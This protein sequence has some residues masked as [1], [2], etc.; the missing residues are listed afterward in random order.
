MSE[1]SVN[2]KKINS[3]ADTI[4]RQAR[5]L[6]EASRSVENVKNKIKMQSESGARIASALKISRD[7]L[8]SQAQSIKNM[9]TA[10]RNIAAAYRQAEEQI[11]GGN[12][13]LGHASL[14]G[15]GSSG[16]GGT[17]TQNGGPSGCS[18]FSPDPVNLNTGNFILDNH[19]LEINGFQPLVFHRFYNSMST[20]SGMLGNDWHAF[21][22]IKLLLAPKNGM[23]GANVCLILEDGREEYFSMKNGKDF[24]P[25]SA[26]TSELFKKED[27][28]YLYRA[29]N[30]DQYHFD[31]TG[32][33]TRYENIRGLGFDLVYEN[34]RLDRIIKDSGEYFALHEND[35][36][37][38]EKIEDHTGRSCRYEYADNHLQK[39]VLPDGSEYHYDYNIFGKISCVINPRDVEAVETQYDTLHRITYQ[40]FA[41]GTTNE[42]TYQDEEKAVIMIERNGTKSIHYH[43]DEYQNVRNVYPDGEESFEYNNRGQKTKIIAKNGNKISLQYDNKGNLAGILTSDGTKIAATYNHLNQLVTMSVN[44]KRKLKNQYNQYGDLLDTEDGLGRRTSYLYNEKGQVTEARMPDGTV[45]SVEYNNCGNPT[46]IHQPNG[47]TIAFSYDA[48]NRLVQKIDALGR[49]SS[50]TYD[51]MGRVLSETRA[52]GKSRIYAYDAGGNI[53]SETDYDGSV[54]TRVFNENNKPVEVVDAAGRKTLL[55]YDSMWNISKITLPNGGIVHYLYDANNNL[56]TVRD[57]ENYETHYRYDAMGNIICKVDAEGAETKY[58]WDESGRCIEVI[59]ADGAKTA[60]GYNEEDQMIY[61]KDAEGIELYLTYDDAGQLIS[62]KDSLGQMRLYEYNELGDIISFTDEHG[63]QTLYDYVQGMNKINKITYPD[64][65]S[66]RYSYDLNGNVTSYTDK[67]ENSFQ[68]VYDNLDRLVCQQGE[69]GETK[70]YTYDL[71]GRVL[72]EKDYDG[73]VTEYA[74]SATGQ[75]LSLK[76]ALG[77][78]TRYSYDETDELAEVSR[79]IS[80]F[81]QQMCLRY[82]RNL[83]GQVTKMTDALGQTEVYQYN[84]VGELIEK[85]DRRNQSTK[86]EYNAV[87]L[88]RKEIWED[89]RQAEYQYTPLRRLSR[90]IDWTGV[91]RVAYN[92]LGKPAKITYPDQK[93]LEYGYDQ[94]GNRT[95]MRYPDG[96]EVTYEYDVLNRIEKVLHHGEAI[97]YGYDTL[98][99]VA[100]RTLPDGSNIQYQYDKNGLMIEMR[101]EDKD[102]VLDV[103]SYGYD[104]HGRKNKYGVYRR[105]DPQEN[106]SYEYSYDKAGRLERVTKD[107]QIIR[108]YTYDSLGNRSGM[109]R[110][111]PMTGQ[112][113]QTEYEYDQRCGLVKST[114]DGLIEEYKYDQRGNMIEHIRNGK[115]KHSYYYD[116]MNRL[117]QTQIGEGIKATYQYNGLGY[118]IG[119]QVT[120]AGRTKSISYLLDYSKIYNNILQREDGLATES[121]FWGNDLELYAQNKDEVGW[122]TTDP[123]GSV[124]RKVDQY[125][126]SFI[127]NY[128]E[129]GNSPARSWNESEFLGYNGFL[130]DPFAGTYFA[131]ARQYRSDVGIFDAMDRICGDVIMPDT[132]NPYAYCVQDPLNRTDKT[133]YWFGL[134][135]A[136][137]AGVGAVGSLAGR[138][139][140]DLVTSAVKGEWTFST[141]Q[142]YA[143]SAIGG[144]VGGVA[145]LYAGPV[146][147][148]IVGGAVSGGVSRLATEGIKAATV[149]GYKFGWDAVKEATFDAAAGAA[150]GKL[151]QVIGGG[152]PGTLWNQ[153]SR[154][155]KNQHGTIANS[156]VLKQKLTS[157]LFKNIPKYLW[158]EG[159]NK[160]MPT[161]ILISQSKKFLTDQLKPLLGLNGGKSTCPAAV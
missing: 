129:F 37:L 26:T 111:N 39:V 93:T 102:G 86:Y 150:F 82:E 8:S 137:A 79:G 142:D 72:S 100:T 147:G 149:P 28:G 91:T 3:F 134:D 24:V 139:A 87:G 41:D 130:F 96:A 64:G 15:G 158:Q 5:D 114:R 75:L 18:I 56:E 44:G 157:T 11:L 38:L 46:V 154:L 105:D 23:A 52:D 108:K 57:A 124:L 40:K 123:L 122:Y 159:R 92:S 83:N 51:S 58:I 144:A 127:G 62:E 1:F 33:Y 10:L 126:T 47:G 132:F 146:A 25:A 22:E 116:A 88:L 36:G 78:V 35:Q 118:R 7:N 107:Q 95:F 27:G 143:G 49:I 155:L 16:G 101:H 140:G 156:N 97:T 133:A 63:L 6:E 138:F 136:I 141:W 119:M 17:Y 43:N 94:K 153:A 9:G 2:T 128:D 135:D 76:D 4:E 67:Y 20:F 45:T 120:E 103:F 30:G 160:F 113:E 112:L 148:P 81:S 71:L 121:Y 60:Y 106:G 85:I 74:Y 19:D 109:L 125:G 59:A 31:E 84:G 161:S 104:L 80:D 90:V 65:T 89:G 34:E 13:R 48:L 50:Y 61:M 115:L 99:N 66:E 55:A 29:L 73:N 12:S 98:G 53:V 110:L 32:T 152:K 14:N 131:Q 42:F 77:N 117:S 69:H 70:E 21:F 54:I 68:Y 151:T 145:T